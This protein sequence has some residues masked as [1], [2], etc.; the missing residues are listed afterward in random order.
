MRPIIAI[1]GNIITGEAE[2][3]HRDINNRPYTEALLAA[4]AVPFVVPCLEDAEAVEMLLEHAHGLLVTGGADVAPHLYGAQP[5]AHL[6]G[7]A[8]L[9]DALDSIAL[10]SIQTKPQVPVLGICRG[11]QAMA[12]FAGGTL[13]QDV[14]SQVPDALQH[15]QQSPGW[16]G[17]H[18]IVIESDSLLAH[19]TGRSRC[20]VNS[21]HHQAVDQ[22]PEGWRVTARTAD[23]VA[24]AL[25]DPQ[26]KFRLGLQFHPEIM[27][28]RHPYMAAIFTSFIAHCCA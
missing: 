22:V 24:E 21:F 2:F 5:N 14:P 12:V 4:G 7:V 25:E 20:M 19:A 16:Y 23:G 18:E 8:P 10:R 1:L 9:R 11:I 13:I 26:A 27:A 28:P 17:S 6:G 15:S 3:S